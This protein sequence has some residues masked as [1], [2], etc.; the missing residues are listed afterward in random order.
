MKIKQYIFI[1]LTTLFISSLY[2]NNLQKNTSAIINEA[3]QT[4]QQTAWF[5]QGSDANTIHLIYV[6]ADPNDSACR[7]LVSILQPYIQKGFLRV[8]WIPANFIQPAIPDKTKTLQQF[9][10]FAKAMNINEEHFVSNTASGGTQSV[11][12][13][14]DGLKKL[15][16]N[17]RLPVIF[18]KT[19]E[20]KVELI[21]G[22]PN[23][24]Q[25]KLVTQSSAE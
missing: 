7:S 3:Y 2:A 21:Q 1:F 14:L 6:V 12:D 19:I 23:A 22:L 15:E 5:Q 25:L 10:T 8:N 18:V 20:G 11:Q 4:A 13:V 17:I 16:K 24:D 9:K